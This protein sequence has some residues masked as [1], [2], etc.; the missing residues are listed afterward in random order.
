MEERKGRNGYG[1]CQNSDHWNSKDKA[2]DIESVCCS[3]FVKEQ[4]SLKA[5]ATDSGVTVY[6]STLAN[7]TR[8]TIKIQNLSLNNS[9]RV[10]VNSGASSRNIVVGPNQEGAITIANLELVRIETILPGR[11]AGV[12]LCFDLQVVSFEAV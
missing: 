6:Q 12:K 5:I 3:N 4:F 2:C 7:I 10:I 8:A 11:L 9:I 1:L